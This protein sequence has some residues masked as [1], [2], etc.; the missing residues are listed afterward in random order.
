MK[1]TTEWHRNS[2][3]GLAISM[4]FLIRGGVEFHTETE[5]THE[6]LCYSKI[7]TVISS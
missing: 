5:E 2:D 7:Q 4:H 6:L 3:E 1:Y